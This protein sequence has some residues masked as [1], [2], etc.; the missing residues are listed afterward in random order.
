MDWTA[1]LAAE[2]SAFRESETP[3][4]YGR[5]A[6]DLL[7]D[8]EEVTIERAH[9]LVHEQ[10][11][12]FLTPHGFE[13][14]GDL[15][16]V[17]GQDAPIRQVFGF[18]KWPE[19][20]F[21]PRWVVSLDFIP[22]IWGGQVAWH[23]SST[24]AWQDLGA[25]AT[26]R[27]MKMNRHCGDGPIRRDHRRIIASAM[28]E[29]APFWAA[30]SSLE[31]LPS[32]IAELETK[33]RSRRWFGVQNLLALIFVAARAGRLDE[34]RASLDEIIA[35]ESYPQETTDH[36]RRLVLEAGADPLP[37]PPPVKRGWLERAL[38]RTPAPRPFTMP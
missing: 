28:T 20:T 2:A 31:K 27:D 32:G 4:V 34:A 16:W 23:R 25:Y 36:L 33:I 9:A 26:A 12:R 30:L 6:E 7:W 3:S 11:E 18:H 22:H 21:G 14:V 29:A 5:D 13:P 17:R 1:K 8:F 24:A 19:G 37:A 15:K 35:T 10:V 38:R